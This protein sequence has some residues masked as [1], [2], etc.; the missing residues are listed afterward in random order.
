MTVFDGHVHIESDVVNQELFLERMGK[1]GVGG[2]LVISLAPARWF[3]HGEGRP[4]AERLDNLSA[5]VVGNE[6]FFPFFWID[7]QEQDALDQVDRAVERGVSGFKIIC[8]SFYPS[9]ARAMEVYAA[10]ARNDRPILFHSGILWDGRDSGR[11]NRPVE[12]ER[13]L[14]V[15]NLRFALAHVSWPWCD[16]AIAVYGKLRHASKLRPALSMEMFIDTTPGTPAIYRKEVLTKLFKGQCDVNDHL[17]FGSDTLA[18][19]YDDSW[20][21]EWI[22]R[23]KGIMTELGV[24]VEVQQKVFSGNLRRFLGISEKQG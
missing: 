19:N 7:P 1:A 6:S 4:A 18:N 13:L 11:Y 22:D 16:E 24:S 12:F 2:A 20:T 3:D 14:E 23:D 9:D 8:S 15:A 5:W 10:I 17:F 21:R